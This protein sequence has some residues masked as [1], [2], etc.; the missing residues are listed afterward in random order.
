MNRKTAWAFV[1]CCSLAVPARGE[2]ADLEVRLAWPDGLAVRCGIPFGGSRLE[3]IGAGGAGE[4]VEIVA[5]LDGPFIRAGPLAATGLLRETAGPLG[6]GPGSDVRTEATGLRLDAS[7]SARMEVS[8]Q[9]T[10]IPGSLAVF[11]LRTPGD[12]RLCSAL[13]GGFLGG[14][15]GPV[16]LGPVM[17]D[18]TAGLGEPGP[19]KDGQDWIRD[20]PP[21]PPQLVLQGAARIRLDLPHVPVAISGGLSAAERA[22]PGWFAIG[23]GSI[24]GG[25]SGVDLLAA[26]ASAGYLELGGGDDPG[27][28]KAGVRLR[29]AGLSGR[30]VVRYVLSIDLPGFGPGPF[31]GTREEIDVVLER[32]WSSGAGAW[33]AGLSASNRI[34]SGADGGQRDDPGGQ[35]S[36]D[37]E[38]DRFVAG[39]ALSIDR[40]EE[41]AVKCSLSTGE[42][43]ERFSASLEAGCAFGDGAT[44]LSICTS[45]GLEF[46]SGEATL[47]AGF[48]DAPLTHGGL[49]DA[50]LSIS[51]GWR[52]AAPDNPASAGDAR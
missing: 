40:D 44:S 16:R 12:A 17:L 27:G 5:G 15:L 13:S 19:S 8:V 31:L 49:R 10:L 3:L 38:G 14:T 30:L 41:V 25:D 9:V 7:R 35:V 52:V 26:A 32:R 20:G 47:H 21:H 39:L 36:V 2:R 37:W 29:L 22:P 33:K 18:A 50:R 48:D 24:G 23:T 28:M 51:L 45:A 42:V 34:E 4:S 43:F 11:W 46:D 1:I 6:F